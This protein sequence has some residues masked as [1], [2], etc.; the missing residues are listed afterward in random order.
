MSLRRGLRQ[1]KRGGRTDGNVGVCEGVE[2]G[3]GTA[4][5]RD[6]GGACYSVD[7]G[8]GVEKRDEYALVCL[9]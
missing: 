2:E 8:Q 5:V 7:G 6:C 1:A 4:C 9:K 3:K